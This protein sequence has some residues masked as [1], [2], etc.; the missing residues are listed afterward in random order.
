M[1]E[2]FGYLDELISGMF[3]N[4]PRQ[5][6]AKIRLAIEAVNQGDLGE[7]L[8]K[9]RQAQAIVDKE[10]LEDWRADV[11]AIWAYYYFANGEEGKV[12]QCIERAYKLEP[13]NQRL[14]KVI[15]FLKARYRGR[16]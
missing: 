8:N 12:R 11:L 1:L 4:A 16:R 7:A 3:D 15:E 5:V 2:K 14:W 13:D 10:N 9:L 6:E